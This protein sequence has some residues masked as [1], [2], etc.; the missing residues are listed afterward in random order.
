MRWLSSGKD[1]LMR[2][3]V[4][5]RWD[6]GEELTD[7]GSTDP[8]NGFQSLN[9]KRKKTNTQDQHQTE[10]MTEM[11]APDPIHRWEVS[12]SRNSHQS[13]DLL[14]LGFFWGGARAVCVCVWVEGEKSLRSSLV[15]IRSS[16]LSWWRR[17]VQPNPIQSLSFFMWERALKLNSRVS[18]F[19]LKKK[20]VFKSHSRLDFSL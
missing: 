8:E 19:F 3:R 18:F 12:I 4:I 17:W 16:C 5:L 13:S 20:K 9:L 11:W 1:F 2:T 10:T 6:W 7:L 15:K 14:W